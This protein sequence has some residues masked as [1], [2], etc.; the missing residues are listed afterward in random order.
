M[1][2]EKTQNKSREIRNIHS[3]LILSRHASPTW[4]ACRD[5]VSSYLVGNACRDEAQRSGT[6]LSI[7][8]SVS[9]SWCLFE[10]RN[11]Y[12]CTFWIKADKPPRPWFL[13]HTAISGLK[14]A[15][16]CGEGGKTCSQQ[17]QLITTKPLFRRRTSFIFTPGSDDT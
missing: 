14:L 8:T 17:L 11:D 5:S 12:V 16:Q 10:V 15:T 7:Y 4:R 9:N 2:T 13:V 3:V 1:T 6:N